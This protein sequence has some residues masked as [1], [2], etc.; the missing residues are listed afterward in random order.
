[1]FILALFAS[2]A[3]SNVENIINYFNRSKKNITVGIV[4]A[5][6]PHAGVI[7]RAQRANVPV[8]VFDRN[9]FYHTGNIERELQEYHVD[10][11]V[12][13]GFLWL[14]PARL[15]QLFPH[16]ILN[17][18]PALLPAH[19]GKGMY[20]MNVH[21]A[22]IAS[23]ERKSGITIHE[24]NSEYDSGKIIFQATCSISPSDTPET[25]AS[26]IHKLEYQHFPRIIEEWVNTFTDL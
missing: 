2:G 23:R 11:I 12:F 21:R 7:E 15:I 22:V 4:F 1:M 13:A 14:A 24:V 18:H 19:G 26:K 5:S 6:H 8:H 16:R 25:L 9:D 10:A 3:G 20:G 17:I